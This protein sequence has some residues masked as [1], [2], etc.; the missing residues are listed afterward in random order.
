MITEE[1]IIHWSGNIKAAPN[2]RQ[3]FNQYCEQYA[4]NTPMR[5]AAFMAQLIHESGSFHYT[6]EIA[7]GEAY[8]GRGDLGNIY[9]GDGIKFKGRGYLQVTG[10]N[11]YK[12][13]SK[14]IFEDENALLK[15]PELLQAPQYAMQ[16]AFIFWN[17]KDLNKYADMDV[18][19]KITS[20]KHGI[21]RPFVYIG[22]LINGGLN[23]MNNRVRIY[24]LICIDLNLPTH[25]IDK[26]V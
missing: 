15:N 12:W 5:T 18:N 10:R 14:E 3:Y 16:S 25:K 11:N 9:P 2:V 22:M 8:E 26:N 6:Q 24:N 7:S 19:Q 13:I 21:V 17:S 4:I 23:G 1:E 20:K